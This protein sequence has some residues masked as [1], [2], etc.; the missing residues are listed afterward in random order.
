[1]SI[2][3]E[4]KRL[5]IREI[6]PGDIDYLLEIYQDI[7]NLRFIPNSNFFWTR[8]KLKEK[9][10]KI[11]QD[12]KYGFGIFVVQIKGHGKII[13]E[14]G[15]FNSFKDSNHFELG[16]I[17]DRKFWRKGYGSEICNSLISYGFS[18]LNLDKITARMFKHNIA[19]IR[20]SEK[21]G[22]KLIQQDHAQ[23]VMDYFEYEI[24]NQKLLK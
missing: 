1:M 17:L 20:L 24:N 15:L 18:T 23:K 9:Y 10:H 19:S 14:A 12:Y 2:L 6:H 16:Y 8:E 22:M 13:G 11:N 4:T 5:L 21:C 7:Q 3:I